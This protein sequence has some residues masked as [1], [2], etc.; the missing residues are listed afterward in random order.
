MTNGVRGLVLAGLI[1]VAGGLDASAQADPAADVDR[2]VAAS[3]AAAWDV[4]VARVHVR[5]SGPT[6]DAADSLQI[7]AGSG[8][9]W[10]V[11]VWQE[12]QV[13]RRFARVGLLE[14]VPVAVRDLGRKHE[15]SPSDYTMEEAIA[16]GPPAEPLPDPSGMTTE[17]VIREGEILRSPAV[18]PP[19]FVR[20]GDAIQAVLREPG[21]VMRL[22][23]EALSSAR[24]GER[25]LLRLASGLRTEGTAIAPGL[26]ELTSGGHR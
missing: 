6:V 26:V 20:G 17:R 3:V 23:A 7:E 25:V 10:I 5:L 13:A 4:P 9:R 15:V 18:R 24:E 2:R 1:T 22:K 19:L 14:R 8:E 21:V 16:W 11:G 12:D